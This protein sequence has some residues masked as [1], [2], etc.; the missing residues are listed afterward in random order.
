MVTLELSEHPLPLAHFEL[1]PIPKRDQLCS[2]LEFGFII[3][4]LLHLGQFNRLRSYLLRELKDRFFSC[5]VPQCQYFP[6][7]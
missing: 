1:V 2:S 3:P 7:F 4:D 6:P 5:E